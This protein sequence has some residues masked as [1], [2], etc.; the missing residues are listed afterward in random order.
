MIETAIPREAD[1]QGP[2]S[3]MSKRG[4]SK[5]MRERECLGEIFIQPEGPRQRTRDLSNLQRMSEPGSEMVAFVKDEDLGLVLEPAEG[6][7]MDDAVAIASKIVACRVGR[8][9]VQAS[10]ALTGM[11][12]VRS[13]LAGCDSTSS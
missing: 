13:P 8:L 7:G 4:M 2:L 1:V 12:G 5:V 11:R 6:G 10:S 9:G 3:R